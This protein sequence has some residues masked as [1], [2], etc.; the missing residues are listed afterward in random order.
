MN[1]YKF[2]ENLYKNNGLI[3]YKLGNT[4][5]L[6]KVHGIDFKAVKGYSELDDIHRSI[7]EKFII[8]FMN[9]LGL[10]SRISLIPKAI[11]Y[12]E[13]I[14]Y[15][16]PEEDYFLVVGGHINIIDR[17]GAK[18]LLRS[19]RDDDYKDKKYTEDEAENYLRFE[20]EHNDN[21]EWLHV[22]K[23]GNEWY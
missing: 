12:V 20:Y 10:E 13:D 15:V 6:L 1:S 21:K 14:S 11:Y 5:D 8:N 22:I 16:V 18:S 4:S 17:N 23:E 7:Y 19:W 3:N 9:G 2:I